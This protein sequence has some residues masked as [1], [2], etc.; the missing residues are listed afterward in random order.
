[1]INKG[2]VNAEIISVAQN[3]RGTGAITLMSAL[4]KNHVNG[5][6]VELMNDVI[7]L[8]T[9]QSI[10][11]GAKINPSAFGHV[12]TPYTSKLS[13][14]SVL[15]FPTNGGI[16]ALNYKNEITAQRQRITNI[17]LGLNKITLVSSAQY[18]TTNYP[19]PIV[20][21]SGTPYVQWNFVTNNNTG[22]NTLTLQNA[23]SASLQLND[24]AKFTPGTSEFV[25]YQSVSG[26][27]LVL[28]PS[29][30]LSTHHYVGEGVRLSVDTDGPLESGYSY[31]FRM[32]PDVYGKLTNVFDF[33]RA[34]GVQ[35][36]IVSTR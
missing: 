11:Y 36:R 6:T 22:T 19:Y 1:V 8:D 13:V 9:L 35:L 30:L 3:N 17:N 34:A 27:D 28:N 16:V 12:V 33:I 4:T 7:Q 25:T 23:L 15:N 21:G 31:A 26:T 5:E 29:T 24:I 18:P 10:H 32:P 14:S 2:N 20:V